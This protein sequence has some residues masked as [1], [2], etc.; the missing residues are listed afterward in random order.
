MLQ[1]TTLTGLALVAA[2][3]SGPAF[4]NTHDEA[5]P[6]SARVSYGDLDLSQ[7]R[8]AQ[9]LLERIHHAAWKVCSISGDSALDWASSSYRKCVRTA[10]AKA[11][12]DL[13]NPM[14]TAAYQSRAPIE[15]AAK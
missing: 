13:N 4:A 9:K 1:K 5:G 6:S 7:G 2:L 12:A 14:V 11:V 8:D 10:S 15:V 3:A